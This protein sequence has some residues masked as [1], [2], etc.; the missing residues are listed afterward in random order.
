L[1]NQNSMDGNIGFEPADRF[2]SGRKTGRKQG[3]RF[4]YWGR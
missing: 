2:G 1:Y 3:H 4:V